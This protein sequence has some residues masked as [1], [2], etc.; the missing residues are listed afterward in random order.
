MKTKAR[1][2]RP[3]VDYFRQAQQI[4]F[5][6]MTFQ[7]V[8]IALSKGLLSAIEEAG[9]KGLSPDEVA[10]AC[11][12]SPYASRVLLEGC[13]AVAALEFEN[14][15]YR[16]A[17]VGRVL[18]HDQLVRINLDFCNDVCYEGAFHLEESLAERKAAGLK[19]FGDWPTIYAGLLQL[20]PKVQKS[21]FGFDHVYSDGIFPK[22]LPELLKRPLNTMLDVGCNT[23][24]WALYALSKVPGLRM[25][26]LDHP[27]QIARATQNL[28]Q[29]G[30]AERAELRAMD[31]LDHS[32][33]FPTGFDAVWM[34]QFLDCFCEEDI[35]ALLARGR[36]A[37]APEGR[38]YIVETYWDKQP[39]AAAKDAILGSSLYFACMANG[40]SR[41]YH[42]D[43]IRA[44]AKAAG[45]AVEREVQHGFHTLLVCKA[46]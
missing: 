27:D 17:P 8:R 36:K 18:L 39:H 20:P 24:K 11:K 33:A 26:M 22:M 19:V 46:P 29:A 13:A 4:A 45:L 42:S 3:A 41:M 16:I 7:A 12:V 28:A 15:R 38:L 2:P 35:T 1:P 21:W 5:A 37:L 44:C 6:P 40:Y 23:G 30:L 34:S 14:G 32:R 9:K 25:T 43:E 31:L 10:G